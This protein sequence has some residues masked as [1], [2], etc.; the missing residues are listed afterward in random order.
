MPALW[1]E[2]KRLYSDA[3]E[4]IDSAWAKWEE[5]READ[6]RGHYFT[7]TELKLALQGCPKLE[8]VFY[9][10]IYLLCA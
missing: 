7:D 2:K 9:K 10:Y 1:L 8:S 4:I 6:F 5:L 3:E